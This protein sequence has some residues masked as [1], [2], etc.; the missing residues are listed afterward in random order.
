MGAGP[1][2]AGDA[3]VSHHS[4]CGRM[5][6]SLVGVV[7]GLCIVLGATVL[8]GWNEG[9]YVTQQAVQADAFAAVQQYSCDSSGTTPTDGATLVFLQGCTLDSL[10][11]WSGGSGATDFQYAVTG[12]WLSTDVQMLQWT[13]QKHTEEHSDGSGGKKTYTWYTHSKGWFADVKPSPTHCDQADWSSSCRVQACGGRYTYPDSASTQPAN[14]ACNP[15]SMPRSP[16]AGK[17]YAPTGSVR[18]GDVA[19]LNSAQLRSLTSSS[20]VVPSNVR[21]EPLGA[22]VR[23]PVNVLNVSNSWWEGGQALTEPGSGARVGDVRL[24]WAVSSATAATTLAAVGADGVMVP[25]AST[26]KARVAGSSTYV[27]E[28]MEGDVP[29][30]ATPHPQASRL[31]S[32]TTTARPHPPPLP[33]PP[34]HQP[35]LTLLLSLSRPHA[36]LPAPARQDFFDELHRRVQAQVWVLRFFSL[37]LF[38]VGPWMVLQPIALAPELVPCVGKSLAELVGR[39]VCCASLLVGLSW[40]LLVT[41]ACWVW[42]RPLVGVP[43]MLVGLGLVGGL[44]RDRKKRRAQ[45]PPALLGESLAAGQALPVA[46]PA[47]GGMLP[48]ATVMAMPVAQ[49]HCDLPMAQPVDEVPMGLPVVQPAEEVPTALHI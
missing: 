15:T 20:A 31:P 3:T 48:T 19:K 4:F 49:P 28:L 23:L 42:F 44:L 1:S 25:W 41:G 13:E 33:P 39:A 22:P 45:R 16:A 5:C 34:T 11:T 36:R 21:E 40:F 2:I 9:D 10:P 47:C 38:W 7:V 6:N 17:Q 14:G 32:T 27:D 18:L 26:V 46:Q 24:S 35:P 30:Q 43:L 12:A 37:L 8:T 29:L